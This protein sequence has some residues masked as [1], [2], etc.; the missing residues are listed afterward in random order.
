MDV[1][2]NLDVDR[3]EN[4]PMIDR[5]NWRVFLHS[6][7]LKLENLIV[8]HINCEF[9]EGFVSIRNKAG[10]LFLIKATI[11]GSFANEALTT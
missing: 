2:G 7:S 8:I 11:S 1:P 6:P 10:S 5:N 9:R 4:I 3:D